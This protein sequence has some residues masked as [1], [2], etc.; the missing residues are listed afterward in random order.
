MKKKMRRI[1]CKYFYIGFKNPKPD[2]CMEYDVLNV[3]ITQAK[4]E[5]DEEKLE[6]L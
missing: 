4:I 5:R 3:R 2:T 6:E 1:S